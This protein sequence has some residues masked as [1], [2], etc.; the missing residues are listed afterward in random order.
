MEEEKDYAENKEILK[1]KNE[2]GK[3]I[4]KEMQKELKGE[5]DKIIEKDRETKKKYME[6]KL[7]KME[8]KQELTKKK[9]KREKTKEKGN[10]DDK[11]EK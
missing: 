10:N 9:R 5:G 2:F 11:K 4:L 8:Q 7:K 3:N 1:T 6:E